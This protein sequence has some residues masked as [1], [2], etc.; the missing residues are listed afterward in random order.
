MAWRRA[1]GI[2]SRGTGEWRPVWGGGNR[3]EAA[4]LERC[5]RNSLARLVENDLTTIAFPAISTGAYGFPIERATRIAITTVSAVLEQTPSV[6]KV[7]FCCFGHNDVEVYER[8]AG[9]LV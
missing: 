4:L 7:V 3:N 6:D 2:W 5:Y 8:L 1:S 9:E